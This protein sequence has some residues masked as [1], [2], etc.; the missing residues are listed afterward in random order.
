MRRHLSRREVVANAVSAS[1]MEAKL[2]VAIDASGGGE[3]NRTCGE[4]DA[5]NWSG[6]AEVGDFV[7]KE[8]PPN[9]ERRR[10]GENGGKDNRQQ[11]SNPDCATIALSVAVGSLT[12]QATI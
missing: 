3:T 6:V 1:L 11:W 5:N 12:G 7:I 9:V 4:A 8:V 2:G 10:H